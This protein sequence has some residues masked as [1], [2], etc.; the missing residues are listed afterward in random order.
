SAITGPLR[1]P[2][3]WMPYSAVRAGN[4]GGSWMGIFNKKPR[5]P[6]EGQSPAASFPAAGSRAD[7]VQQ[8][9]EQ[10]RQLQAQAQ[11][12]QAQAMQQTAAY[13][14]ASGASAAG[15]GAAGARAGAG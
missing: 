8:M 14:Q 11:A 4:A 10:A 6:E 12:M 15:A 7:F 1:D 3:P 13:R 2:V 5:K 9:K